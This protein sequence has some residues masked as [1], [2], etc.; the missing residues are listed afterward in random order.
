MLPLNSQDRKLQLLIETTGNNGFGATF[1]PDGNWI[2]YTSA[3]SGRNEVYVRPFRSGSG[4]IQISTNG[5]SEPLWARGGEIFYREADKMMAVQV[6]LQPTL[7]AGK[8]HELFK[9]PFVLL[10]TNHHSLS[11]D[12]RFLLLKAGEQEQTA[13]QINVVLNWAEELNRR[14][15]A[16]TK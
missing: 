6:V 13:S 15:P 1:A 7:T 4:K 11:G 12:G 9:F 14:V 2:A 10:G 16:G 5:G 3:E 8:P